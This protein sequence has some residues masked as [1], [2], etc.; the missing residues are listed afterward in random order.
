MRIA[1]LFFVAKAH[2]VAEM[3][4]DHILRELAA[5]RAA[6]AASDAARAAAD[7]RAERVEK[8]LFFTQMRSISSSLSSDTSSKTDEVRRGAPAPAA[9]ADDGFLELFPL[10]AESKVIEVW[11]KFRAMHAREWMVPAVA[12]AAAGASNRKNNLNENK[13]VHPTIALILHAAA[14]TTL[15]VWHDS[16]A[17]DDV[18]RAHVR[19]DF[20]LTSL[21]DAAPSTIG[22][23]LVCE[24]KLPGSFES[25]AFQTRA[26]C[27]RCVYKRCCEADA[28]GEALDGIAAFG[29]AT[30]GITLAVVRV[31]SGAPPAG[32]SFAGAKPCPVLQSAQLALLP[33]WDFCTPP[34]SSD[35]TE[36][37]AGFRALLRVCSAP[38][39]LGGDVVLDSL[40]VSLALCSG[41]GGHMLAAP[42]NEVTLSLGKRLGS[43]GTSDVYACDGGDA[44]FGVEWRVCVLKTARTATSDIAADFDAERSALLALRDAGEHGLVPRCIAAGWRVRGAS[45]AAAGVAAD[46]AQWRVLLLRPRAQPLDAW[47]ASRVGALVAAAAA[48]AACEGESCGEAAAA[49]AANAAAAARLECADATLLRVLDALIAAEQKGLVHCDVRP[50]NIVVECDAGGGGDGGGGGGAEGAAQPLLADWGSVCSARK[51]IVRRGVAAFAD[52]RIFTVAGL[53]ARSHI[54]ALGALFTWLA[55]AC[56]DACTAPWIAYEE[57]A[58]GEEQ[59]FIARGRWLA[60]RSSSSALSSAAAGGAGDDSSDSGG[61]AARRERVARV[62][63]AA[64]ALEE[65]DGGSSTNALRLAREAVIGARPDSL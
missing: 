28:R 22:A 52:R 8:E 37:P 63:R 41:A 56:S 34:S 61:T 33:G 2:G 18:A 48:A 10:V 12:K 27:R 45:H 60:E 17:P 53:P 39:A 57:A 32:A 55:I 16:P 21:R 4:I 14:S 5:A 31:A 64:M 15:R 59:L 9:I 42:H 49:A 13:D 51:R 44:F 1:P 3:D 36:P 24:V 40:R 65:A 43:G 58:A 26:Y 38:S 54:D 6:L 25:A 23:K 11:G 62:A 47:V 29:I 50:S 19:P 20:T 7:E 35:W 30:D 46:A